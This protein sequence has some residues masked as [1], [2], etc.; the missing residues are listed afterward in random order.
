MDEGLQKSKTHDSLSSSNSSS[1]DHKFTTRLVSTKSIENS[2]TESSSSPR[3]AS[4]S[5]CDI[6][7]A[8]A[9]ITRDE[10][11]RFSDGIV[12]STSNEKKRSLR[13]QA[14]I[15]DT[16]ETIYCESVSSN[17]ALATLVSADEHDQHLQCPDDLID[18]P[19]TTQNLSN[20]TNNHCCD[21]DE[22]KR[23]SDCCCVDNSSC[24]KSM[25]KI[26]KK[27]QKLAKKVA[28][29]S[30]DMAEIRGMLSNV[31]SVRMEPGF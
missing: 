28:K 22:S 10:G 5:S 11:R 7:E 8:Y 21:N 26:F 4:A 17:S 19:E 12:N 27:N 18:H 29:N 20:N 23:D 31:M 30:K 24:C 14:R 25:R 16:E 6:P 1:I 13:R 2:D 15:S 9:R 3:R